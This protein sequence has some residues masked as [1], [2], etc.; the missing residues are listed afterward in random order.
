LAPVSFSA[1]PAICT[2]PPHPD[3]PRTV[4][5]L[6][7]LCPAVRAAPHV[8]LAL[9]AAALLLLHPQPTLW[10]LEALPLLRAPQAGAPPTQVSSCLPPGALVV[11]DHQLPRVESLAIGGTILTN[12]E[13]DPDVYPC[14]E[15]HGGVDTRILGRLIHERFRLERYQ[16]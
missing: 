4:W 3:V 6:T 10:L 11:P 8:G 15:A 1:R 14:A 7:S 2:A 9:P 13:I 12:A 16:T 5:A